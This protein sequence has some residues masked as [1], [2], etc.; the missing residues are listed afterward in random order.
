MMYATLRK[1]KYHRELVEFSMFCLPNRH[2]PTHAGQAV[3]Q[4]IAVLAK[5]SAMYEVIAH[6]KVLCEIL[7]NEDTV[8]IIRQRSKQSNFIS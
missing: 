6:S 1:Y 3:N 2:T 5:T 4:N 7:K 8:S